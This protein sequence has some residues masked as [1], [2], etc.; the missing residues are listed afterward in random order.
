MDVVCRLGKGR[1]IGV[2]DFADIASVP[3]SSVGWADDGNLRVTFDGDLTPVQRQR[4]IL[5]ITSCD[6]VE[7]KQRVAC[8]AFLTLD[9]PTLV[10]TVA[11]VKR[12]TRLVLSLDDA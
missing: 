9:A 3:V 11:Q 2:D 10:Q 12:L 6:A 5:R 4:V 1:E 7:E 8:A